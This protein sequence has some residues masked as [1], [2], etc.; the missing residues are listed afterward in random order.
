MPVRVGKTSIID[1]LF[2]PQ[3]EQRQPAQV[4]G[5]GFLPITIVFFP[6]VCP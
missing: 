1:Q 6:R 2:Q 3:R 4:N 5:S